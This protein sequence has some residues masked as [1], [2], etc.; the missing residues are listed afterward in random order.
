LNG[1]QTRSRQA[2]VREEERH[3][4]I[5]DPA[6]RLLCKSVHGILGRVVGS[7]EA[8]TQMQ[9]QIWST[10]IYL[11]PPSLWITI[12]PSDINNPI[13]QL[14][15]GANVASIDGATH[16][17]SD[18]TRHAQVIAEDPFACVYEVTIAFPVPI[19]S[20]KQKSPKKDYCLITN[21]YLFC[22]HVSGLCD[23]KLP[24]FRYLSLYDT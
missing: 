15:A 22:S 24:W 2:A 5:S 21:L 4:A 7:N 16:C 23:L 8:R 6:V 18:P 1:R 11:G 9:S 14:F 13:A 17:T 19:S 12:N 3:R 10:S 20:C